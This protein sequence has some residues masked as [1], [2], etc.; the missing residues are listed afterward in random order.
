MMFLLM[1]SIVCS[2]YHQFTRLLCVRRDAME[3]IPVLRTAIERYRNSPSH[4]TAIH[5]D[6]IQVD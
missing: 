5:S 4:L 6:L 1:I 2:L 3:G